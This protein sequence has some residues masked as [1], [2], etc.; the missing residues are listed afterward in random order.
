M[1]TRPRVLVAAVALVCLLVVVAALFGPDD[2]ATSATSATSAPEEAPPAS[3]P[4]PTAPDISL[5]GEATVSDSPFV[6]DVPVPSRM[7]LWNHDRYGAE[8]TLHGNVWR[9]AWNLPDD[10]SRPDLDAF[11]D[12]AMPE[13]ADFGE[14]RWCRM[15]Q[16]DSQLNETQRLYQKPGTEAI[17]DVTIYDTGVMIGT[18]ESGP[19]GSRD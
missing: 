4:W 3:T 15:E 17:L 1:Q 14:W 8:S 10:L 16:I 7:V 13:G 19:C 18:D 9:A 12:G 6:E 5:G 2:S 11:Y